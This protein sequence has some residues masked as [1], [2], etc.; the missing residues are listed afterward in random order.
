MPDQEVL[1]F[2]EGG[3]ITVE[4][5]KIEHTLAELWA[6]AAEAAA[7]G[8]GGP[9]VTKVSLGTICVVT[10][11]ARER[12]VGDLWN[13][14]SERHPS[15]AILV[16]IDPH[17]DSALTSQVSAA[18][19]LAAPSQPQVCS[20]RIRLGV[21]PDG[22]D[23]LVG[24]V[25]PL[26]E[27]DVPA[28]LWWDLPTVPP[29]ELCAKLGRVMDRCVTDLTRSADAAGIYRTLVEQGCEPISDLAWF[30]ANKWREAVARG[31]DSP[32]YLTALPAIERIE[33]L[34]AAATDG[35][36]LPAAL[37]G[38]WVAGQL[39]W[40]PSDWLDPPEHSVDGGTCLVSH[41]HWQR[42]DGSDGAVDIATVPVADGRP[43][44][45][46]ALK[47]SAPAHD[48]AWSYER[49]H[50]RPRELRVE[51][52][53]EL[54]CQLPVHVPAP[55]PQRLEVLEHTLMSPNRTATRDR[56]LRLA[57]WLL[58]WVVNDG[59]VD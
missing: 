32:S 50:D 43:G 35:E 20:E 57:G 48:A 24:A 39:G 27:P 8:P 31:F 46:Q 49:L 33:V 11:A 47:L 54:W 53:H 37:L 1:N 44:R 58:G 51:A 10:S 25:L 42:R 23:R 16:V 7:D 38:G 41:T 14:L 2:L 18:C 29:K 21:G 26:L 36:L 17:A 5:A 12:E 22:L 34:G 59:E 9:A 45:L 55:R 15:R 3:A 40:T 4:P 52:H 13:R 6:P 56:S 19:H 30:R 28:T